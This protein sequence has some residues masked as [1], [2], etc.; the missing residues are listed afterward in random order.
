MPTSWAWHHWRGSLEYDSNK[1]TFN[2]DVPELSWV[3]EAPNRVP[4]GII[5]LK[6]ASTYEMAHNN[7]KILT[8]KAALLSLPPSFCTS[9]KKC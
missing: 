9:G 4:W 5:A 7:N 1:K 6:N 3:L 2:I 8:M